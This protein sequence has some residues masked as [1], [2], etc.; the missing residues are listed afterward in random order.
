MALAHD[1]GVARGGIIVIAVHGKAAAARGGRSACEV[2]CV[3]RSLHPDGSG[4][5][6][7]PPGGGG[8]TV[9]VATAGGTLAARRAGP[10]TEIW[11]SSHSTTAPIGRYST[12]R[13]G[14]S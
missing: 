11:P 1:G 2:A 7:L 10:S 4:P 14:S 3:K 8:H 5:A 12:G 13:R 9:R 6:S